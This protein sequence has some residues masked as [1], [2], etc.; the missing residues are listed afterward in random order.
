MSKR[1]HA[2]VL[3][4]FFAS[5]SAT[6]CG[7]SP[8]RDDPHDPTQ[9]PASDKS[10]ALLG[11]QTWA[12]TGTPEDGE[13]LGLGETTD[14]DTKLIR[15]H[16]HIQRGPD[17]S[18]SIDVDLP[19][20]W[21]FS[22]LRGQLPVVS[23]GIPKDVAFAL[24]ASALD[25]PQPEAK[26]AGSTVLVQTVILPQTDQLIVN[27]VCI[28]YM[29]NQLLPEAT[30]HVVTM[31]EAFDI[32]RQFDECKLGEDDVPGPGQKGE[33][34]AYNTCLDAVNSA[35]CDADALYKIVLAG[36]VVQTS[37]M[38][39]CSYA[40]PTKTASGAPT[41]CFSLTTECITRDACTA[42]KGTAA[43]GSCEPSTPSVPS[44]CN[45]R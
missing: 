20:A 25:A 38:V 2:F 41:R 14:P 7:S 27:N 43:S 8:R 12:L 16:A 15:V 26:P 11:V 44:K 10:H 1:T 9:W 40:A 17:G 36:N 33:E 21:K 29:T 3:G 28:A 19:Q 32:L 4:F 6:A 37:D 30:R 42:H 39:S 24:A 22:F 23:D 34:Q 5:I 13:L 35:G 31:Q 18:F 45:G